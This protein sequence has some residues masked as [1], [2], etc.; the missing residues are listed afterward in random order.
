MAIQKKLMCFSVIT[1]LLFLISMII[2]P[3]SSVRADGTH[4]ITVNSYT[5]DAHGSESL[6]KTSAA[7]GEIVTIT[8]T[9]DEGYSLYGLY[10]SLVNDYFGEL[11]LSKVSNNK[12]SFVMPDDDVDITV[13]YSPLHTVTV[14][15][16]EG[17]ENFVQEYFGQERTVALNDFSMVKISKAEK[18]KSTVTTEVFGETCGDAVNSLSEMIRKGFEKDLYDGVQKVYLFGINKTYADLDEYAND[19]EYFTGLTDGRVFYALWTDPAKATITINAPACDDEITKVTKRNVGCLSPDPEIV[20]E[21]N[22]SEKDYYILFAYYTYDGILETGEKYSLEGK[23]F[24][25]LYLPLD[26]AWGYYLPDDPSDYLTIE[27]GEFDR[28]SSD[29]S[30]Y[31]NV[32]I[33]HDLGE[34]VTVDPDCTNAGSKTY[35]C[36]KCDFVKV[37]PIDALGHDWGEWKE[38]KAAT[39]DAEG[40]ETRTCS[41]CDSKETRPVDKLKPEPTTAPSATPTTKPE[42]TK[43]PTSKPTA[44]PKAKLTIDQTSVNTVCGKVFVL[45]AK[46]TGSDAKI[47]WKSSDKNIASVDG[48]GRVTAKKAGNVTITASAAG[49]TVSCT[50]TVHY[51]DVMNLSDFW[52]TPTY[53]LT[54]LGVVKGYDKQTLFKPANNC[55]RA[56]MVTFIWRLQ[57][58]PEPKTKTCK[59]KDVKSSDYFYKACIWGNENK[60]VE[61]YKDGTFGPQIICARKHAVTF[62]W[63][64]AGKPTP[65]SKTNKFKD[66]KEKDYFYKATLWASEKGILA[67]YKDGTFKPDG[68]CLRR[69]MVTFLYKFDKAVNK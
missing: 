32:R 52:Y 11:K 2:V 31:I 23:E 20:I 49:K 28:S 43:S 57:G 36:A 63:R 13:H 18:G 35:K 33:R 62:L 45:K 16:G 47:S 51:K 44:D 46:L 61:G 24:I 38:T 37:D 7:Q 53:Y 21:G 26:I 30:I 25:S 34:P 41:R 27:G 14:D 40:E 15:F 48:Q 59:F 60:I 58:E 64:L 3:G 8:L 10:A 12:Y 39:V 67:G 19:P 66:V 22:V 29:G 65:A 55:T 68:D 42:P 5:W 4:N 54:N 6:D 50:V 69:Q 17:H 9:P 56:Q 1:A